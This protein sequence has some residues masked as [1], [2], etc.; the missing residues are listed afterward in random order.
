MDVAGRQVQVGV[1][2]DARAVPG[3]AVRQRAV[4]GRVAAGGQVVLFQEG[5]QA[6]QRRVDLHGG[7]RGS[8]CPARLVLVREIRRHIPDR[9]GRTRWL[10]ARLLCSWRNC[11]SIFCVTAFGCT[12]PLRMPS[13]MLAMAWSIQAGSCSRRLR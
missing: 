11:G 6:R 4:A 5:V 9:R 7:L 13:F 10:P 3:G 1:V 8:P 12:T 2:A